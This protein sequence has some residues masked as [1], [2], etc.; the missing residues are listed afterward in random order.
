[1]DRRSGYRRARTVRPRLSAVA[2]L[3]AAICVGYGV[4]DIVLGIMLFVVQAEE[5]SLL[6]VN[7]LFTY[8]FW[9][10]MFFSLG[11]LILLAIK[12]NAW[13]MIR[14]TLFIGAFVNIWC[15]FTLAIRMAMGVP[16]NLM[17]LCLWVFLIYVQVELYTNFLPLDKLEVKR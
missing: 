15:L 14:R 8:R 5:R 11:V 3:T 12:S 9:S 1:M 10:L 4:L 2:P 13:R 6:S 17:M 7:D 16:D